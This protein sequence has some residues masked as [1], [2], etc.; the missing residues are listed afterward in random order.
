MKYKGKISSLKAAILAENI[1]I[2]PIFV[3]SPGGNI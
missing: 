3:N 2:I 1:I